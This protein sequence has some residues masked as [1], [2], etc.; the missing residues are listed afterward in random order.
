MKYQKKERKTYES[1]SKGKCEPV[2]WLGRKDC[3]CNRCRERNWK[4]NCRNAGIVVTMNPETHN[5]VRTAS[6]MEVGEGE[7][8]KIDEYRYE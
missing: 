8:V 2:L 6:I 7:F 5:P 4:S 1:E 3:N